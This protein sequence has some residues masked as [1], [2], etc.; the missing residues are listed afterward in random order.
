VCGIVGYVGKRDVT[1]VLIEGLHRLEYRG[2][3]SAGLAV[4][5]RGRLNIT[6]TAGRVQDLRDKL[7]AKQSPNG[8]SGTSS[9]TTTGIGHTRWATHGEPNETNAHPHTDTTGRIAIVHN[10]IIENAEQLRAQLQKSGVTLVSDTDTEALAHMIAAELAAGADGA[11]SPVSLE[12]AVVATLSRVEGAYGLVVLDTKHPDQLVVARNGS[13]IVL[14]LGNGEMFVASDVAALVR[15][16][17]QVIYL[18]DGEVATIKPTDYHTR[19]L[20]PHA[21]S[22]STVTSTDTRRP[23]TV[24]SDAEAYELGQ[25]PDYMSKEIHEQPEAIRRALRGRLDDRFATARLGG[26]N[27]DARHLRNIRRV[28]F[29][30]CGSAY[31]AGQMGAALVEELAR[32]PADAEPASEFRYRSPVV[33]P[34]TLYVAVSQSG[35]TI[36][37]LMAVQELKRKGGQVIGAVNVVGSAIGRECGHGIFLHAGPEVAVASTKALTNMATNF[38][39]LALLLGRVRD[40]SAASGERIVNGLRNL[41]ELVHQILAT[42]GEIAAVAHSYAGAAHMFFI[43]RVH[44]WP[45]AREGA[46]KLKEISYVHAEAYQAGELKHGPLALIQPDMPSVVIIPNDELIAKNISTIEQIKAR[47]GPVIAVTSADIPDGLADATIRLPKAE[48]ELEP[49][50]FNIPLQLLAYHAAEKLGRDIDKPRNLAK[51]VTVE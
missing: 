24:E 31:Y 10:G 5:N 41:P 38:V 18:E 48:P 27:L 26:I 1:P 39:L 23:Q 17:N 37:T 16:T 9:K 45:V 12:D 2:Y 34:D 42:E 50:L 43:G 13:P 3:D 4:L 30:G 11:D 29:L 19:A 21:D 44:G 40:L 15:Y 35:E 28:K 51:S 22:G 33:D 47:G 32:I 14:G 25:Y 49:V 36:D 46:Q 8:T 7:A 6:K 20:A